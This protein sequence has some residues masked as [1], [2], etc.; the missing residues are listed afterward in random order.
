MSPPPPSEISI[1]ECIAVVMKPVEGG[2]SMAFPKPPKFSDKLAERQF[3]KERLAAALRIFAKNGFDEGVGSFP[4][5]Y[6]S[7]FPKINMQK[8]VILL[9]AIL[10]IQQRFGSIPSELI[11]P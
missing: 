6:R 7:L 1:E 9:F 8:L 2:E 4:L 5:L 10:L 3:L 11:S